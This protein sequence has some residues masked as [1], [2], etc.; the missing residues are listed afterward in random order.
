MKLR[1]WGARGST[2][3]P[4]SANARYGGN[5]TCV[6]VRLENGTILI[7]DCG[8]GLRGLGKSHTAEFGPQPVAGY[9]FLT[10]FHWDHIQ[11]IPFFTPLYKKGNSFFF[12]SVSL[13]AEEL[14]GAVEGQ[15]VSPYFPVDMSIM[16]AVR[17]FYDIG[18]EPVDI[19]GAVV[20]SAQLNHPQGCVAYRVEADGGALVFATDHEHG[21]AAHDEN[22]RRIARGADVFIYDA[23]YTPEEYEREK[24]GWGH[25]T[26][27][28]GV[29]FARDAGARQLV[30]CHHDPDRDDR[31][32]D[33]ILRE[34]RKQFPNTLAA[35]E[36]LVLDI[37]PRARPK[38]RST[39][40]KRST[41]RM[42]NR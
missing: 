15:M 13:K 6:E 30:L 42:R 20:S 28:E 4:E 29:K 36:G 39:S 19:H 33:R 11:G 34:A 9:I 26:W 21:S 31:M 3:T 38:S 23:Q 24:K 40:R 35:S 1:V 32:L 8:S 16:G 14:Q 17:N 25:S 27:A 22:V 12:H 41:S 7:L 18:T 2:P 37:P 5:T 10:H